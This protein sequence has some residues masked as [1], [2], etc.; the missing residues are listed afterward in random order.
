MTRRTASVFSIGVATAMSVGVLGFAIPALGA[1]SSAREEPCANNRTCTFAGGVNHDGGSYETL[2]TVRSPGT[3]LANLDPGLR[4][5]LSSWKNTSSTG[6][7]FFYG[8]GGNG[9]CVSMFA[10]DQASASVGNP[11]DNKA[12]SHSY[13][14]RCN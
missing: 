1:Q 6:A 4:F 5:R 14:R 3:S 13:T 2:L 12:Q 7:R 9:T 11:D 10:N 8:L